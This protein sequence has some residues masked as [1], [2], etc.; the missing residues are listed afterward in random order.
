MSLFRVDVVRI[1]FLE[2]EVFKRFVRGVERRAVY[3]GGEDVSW[4]SLVCV[5]YWERG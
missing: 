3:V 1:I 4:G 2:K 5:G